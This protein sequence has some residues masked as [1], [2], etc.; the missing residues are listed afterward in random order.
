M[1]STVKLALWLTLGTLIGVA[2][3]GYMATTQA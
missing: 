2:L 1:N 3:A